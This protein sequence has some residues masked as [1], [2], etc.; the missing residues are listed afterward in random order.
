MTNDASLSPSTSLL[1]SLCNA[2]LNE[3]LN[4]SACVRAQHLLTLLL[5]GIRSSSNMLP[6]CT[7]M[8]PWALCRCLPGANCVDC[9]WA[10]ASVGE[11][12]EDTAV[13]G[14]SS[15]CRGRGRGRGKRSD[16]ICLLPAHPLSQSQR[17]RAQE[18]ATPT[19]FPQPTCVCPSVYVC[20]RV[21]VFVSMLNYCD[22]ISW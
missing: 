9:A 7:N 4:S 6:C 13:V 20:V 18:S 5:A 22:K 19:G 17:C 14:C 1:T 11:G 16:D 3:R 8:L 10:W 15:R 2:K 21:S 12:N